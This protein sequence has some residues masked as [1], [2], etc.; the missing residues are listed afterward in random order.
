MTVEE[1]HAASGFMRPEA[2]DPA[3]EPSNVSDQ[4]EVEPAIGQGSEVDPPLPPTPIADPIAYE[5][6]APVE[7]PAVA[8][9][10][11]DVEPPRIEP[12]ALAGLEEFLNAILR[13]RAERVGAQ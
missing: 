4:I 3:P 7:M 8:A 11:V 9:P 10:I 5:K 12:P 2:Q 1:I 6:P 13:A